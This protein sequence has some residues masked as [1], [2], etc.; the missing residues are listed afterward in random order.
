M[1]RRSVQFLSNIYTLNRFSIIHYKINFINLYRTI[2]QI[3]QSRMHMQTTQL[4]P[5][6]NPT[7]RQFFI[8]PRLYVSKVPKGTNRYRDDATCRYSVVNTNLA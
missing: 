5:K 6:L 1:L 7:V 8:A 2:Y 4:R 3:V